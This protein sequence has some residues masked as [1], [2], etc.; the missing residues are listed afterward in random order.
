MRAQI[1]PKLSS[2]EPDVVLVPAGQFQMGTSRRA[3]RQARIAWWDWMTR[4]TPAHFFY[5]PD[6]AVGRWPVTNA[7]YARFV[8]DDGYH[9][10]EFWTE[11]GWRIKYQ[12]QWNG[13]RYRI[14]PCWNGDACPVVGVSWFEAVAFCRWLSRVTDRPFRLPTEA[15]WEKAARGPSGH[16]WPWGNRWK[17]AYCNNWEIRRRQTTPVHHFSPRGDSPYGA[18]DTVGNVW[19]WCATQSL[20]AYPLAPPTEEWTPENLAGTVARTLRGG[21][22]G[23]IRNLARCTYRTL[24][25]PALRV[26]DCGFRLA[27]SI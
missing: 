5:L 23:C 10:P 14:N 4:E 19:E 12:Q 8:A 22:W 25:E 21:S 13:P 11:A 18:S 16:M 6:Y 7:E 2:L 20:P 27:L 9:W 17:P 3:L 24:R 1:L 15:E 26:N